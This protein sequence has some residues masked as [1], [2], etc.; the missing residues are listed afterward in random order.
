LDSA[1]LPW[2]SVA[3][4]PESPPIL[5]TVRTPPASR[6]IEM[7][8]F[9]AVQLLDV[10]GPLQ[11]F[12]TANE[13]IAKAGRPH[14]YTV[15]I[16]ARQV[17]NVTASAGIMLG[18]QSLSPPGSPVD[19]LIVAGGPGVKAAA[20]ERELVAW[21]TA[22]AAAARRTASVCTGAYLLAKTGILDGRRATTHWS[23]C[24]HLARSFPAV[25]VDPDPIFVRDGPVWTSAGVTAGIDLALA[26]LEEDLGRDVAL[27][28]ARYLV[29]FLKRPGGQAQFSAALSLQAGEAPFGKLHA[30]IDANLA[31]DLSLATLADQAGMSDRSFSRHYLEATGLTPARAVERL[32]VE[33]ARRLLCD[34]RAPI[35]RIARQCGFGTEETMRRSFL[36]LL[37]TSPQDYRARFSP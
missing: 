21:V 19:T 14:P 27:A 18:T 1:I 25:R 35:K 3:V 5:P 7:V 6:V 23:F 16:V 34:T 20:E 17:P 31:R 22:R 24:D 8:A 2:H 33:A 29:V 9:D 32:R 37:S 4:M 10:T 26:L 28:V 15:R 11:V 12:A 36:R 30:W 13:T